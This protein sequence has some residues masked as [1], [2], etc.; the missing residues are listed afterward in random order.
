MIDLTLSVLS[1]E[2]SNGPQWPSLLFYLYTTNTITIMILVITCCLIV[3]SLCRIVAGNLAHDQV[4]RPHV[5][6]GVSPWEHWTREVAKFKHRPQREK[7]CKKRF[8][9]VAKPKIINLP[10][11]ERTTVQKLKVL[12]HCSRSH[13]NSKNK[14]L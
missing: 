5:E 13:D 2:A 6:E 4:T 7:K 10:L 1:Q 11:E 12:L 14:K 9:G 3:E 8:S